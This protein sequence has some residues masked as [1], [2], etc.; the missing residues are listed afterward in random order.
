MNAVGKNERSE[1]YELSEQT[2]KGKRLLMPWFDAVDE[3]RHR[4]C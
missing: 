1:T 4:V 3:A 2:K